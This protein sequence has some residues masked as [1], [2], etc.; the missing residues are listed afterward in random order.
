M[1]AEAGAGDKSLELYV[2]NV[3]RSRSNGQ[4]V[5]DSRWNCPHKQD[6]RTKS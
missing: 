2:V 3:R 5:R 6:Q 4:N 1:S